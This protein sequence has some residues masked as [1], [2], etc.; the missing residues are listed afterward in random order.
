VRRF[1]GVTGV[2]RTNGRPA[3][4]DAREL[5]AIRRLVFSCFRVA[6]H[7]FQELGAAVEVVRGPLSG[8][9]GAL[10]R[11]NGATGLAV[12]VTLLRRSA[13]VVIHPA[14]VTPV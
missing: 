8:V 13:A 10:V 5:D 11:R 14:D 3:P 12:P 4:I 9:R 1:G 7:P 2:V 6:P